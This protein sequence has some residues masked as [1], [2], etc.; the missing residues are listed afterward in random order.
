MWRHFWFVV[1]CLGIVGCGGAAGEAPGGGGAP[2]A[3]DSLGVYEAAFRFRLQKQPKNV[4][5]FLSV[6]GKDAPAEVLDKLRKDWPN[7]KPRS[8]AP[9]DKGLWVYVD[10]LKWTG[11][12]TAE[13]K[14]GYW[15]PTKFAGEGYFAT[16]HLVHQGGSWI[17]QKV[18][19][20]VMS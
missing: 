7:L 11:Q 8:A 17:V 9:K 6:D 3:K 5:A 15:F 14:A 20:E 16:H 12:G 10:E 4:E 1:L 13:V 19:N 2:A 18:S